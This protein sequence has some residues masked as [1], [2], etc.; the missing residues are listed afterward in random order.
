MSRLMASAREPC[1]EPSLQFSM[2]AS[3]VP[4]TRRELQELDGRLRQELDA[5]SAEVQQ[6]RELPKLIILDLLG[7]PVYLEEDS[8]EYHNAR[9]M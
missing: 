3:D 7:N 2:S 1:R 4:A 6:L 8:N 5:L 9:V